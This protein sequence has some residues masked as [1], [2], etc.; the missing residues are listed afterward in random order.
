[1]ALKDCGMCI[2]SVEKLTAVDIFMEADNHIRYIRRWTKHSFIPP[3]S[4][5]QSLVSGYY[6]R[7][8]LGFCDTTVAG[9]ED[10]RWIQKSFASLKQRNR[11]LDDNN[12]WCNQIGL[13]FQMLS[14]KILREKGKKLFFYWIKEKDCNRGKQQINLHTVDRSDV[15]EKFYFCVPILSLSTIHSDALQL[16]SSDRLYHFSGK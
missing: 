7:L 6:Y 5:W 4:F 12:W 10:F 15:P 14:F 16:T 1:M 2:T 9:K 13:E 3:K 8:S 11:T